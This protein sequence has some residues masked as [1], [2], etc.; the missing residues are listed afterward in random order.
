M[1]ALIQILDIVQ[2]KL[3][4][5]VPFSVPLSQRKN[6]GDAQKRRNVYQNLVCDTEMM[7]SILSI[8]SRYRNS[9]TYVTRIAGLC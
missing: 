1:F 2:E 8:P 7:N 3:S 4:L 9:I 6:I 5:K